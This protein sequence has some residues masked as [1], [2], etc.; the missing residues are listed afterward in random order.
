MNKLRL[1]PL[2]AP[3]VYRR[4][5]ALA[6]AL[7]PVLAFAGPTGGTVIA[8]EV[9]IG[10][11][12]VLTTLVQQNS[13]T[14]V[15]NWQQ[16]NVAGQEMV[17]FVQPSASAAILNRIVGGSPSE[18]LGNI[19]ANGRVFLINTQGV[20]FGA[21]S[22]VDVAGLVASTLDISDADF[23]NGRYVL[24]GNGS[25]AGVVNQGQIKTADGGFVVLAG[26]S[27][28]NSGLIQARLGDIVL[29]SGSAMTLDLAGDGLI[30]YLSLIHI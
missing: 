3:L 19:S 26:D 6:P 22:R 14:A 9:N 1:N 28:R 11:P 17:Q 25:G 21:G 23:M 4:W 2:R 18:I 20:M 5:L 30:N 24:A 16:F 13:Q 27:A 15:V 12:D 7:T 29:A 10:Q 8:G